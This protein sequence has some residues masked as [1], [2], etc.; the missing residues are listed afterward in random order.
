MTVAVELDTVSV[1]VIQEVVT[2]TEVFLEVSVVT[3]SEETVQV[4][5]EGGQG[6][7][8][9]SAYQ[10]AVKYGFVG[11]EQQWLESIGGQP[12]YLGK[13]LVREGGKLTEVRLY[14]DAEKTV[15]AKSLHLVQENGVLA[16]VEERN[17]EGVVVKIKTLQRDAQGTL[18]GVAYA[19]S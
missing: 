9:I 2:D 1:E 3:A 14:E 19:N 5:V 6:P 15:L 13:D 18:V 7:A 16:R 10:S 4:L 12:T 11:S 17:P 8:G